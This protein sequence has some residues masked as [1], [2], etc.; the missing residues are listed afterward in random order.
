MEESGR[1][2]EQR[3]AHLA[4]LKEISGRKLMFSFIR[5]ESIMNLIKP[6]M[7]FPTSSFWAL[8][9]LHL[10]SRQSCALSNTRCYSSLKSHDK[11]F[12]VTVKNGDIHDITTDSQFAKM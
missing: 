12:L 3:L 2:W 10:A 4:H 11:S 5:I 6:D 8:V 9:A 7:Y 1:E